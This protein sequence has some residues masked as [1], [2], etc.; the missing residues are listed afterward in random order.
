MPVSEGASRTAARR[1]RSWAFMLPI[2]WL[3]LTEAV[4]RE[5]RVDRVTVVH[6]DKLP[7]VRR[8][9]GL[10]V[11]VSEVKRAIR[12]WDFFDSGEAFAVVRHT[13]DPE[14]IETKAMEIIREELA[15]LAASQLGYS[16]RS[17]MG[18]IVAPGEAYHPYVSYLAVSD[19]D[20]TRFG[21]FLKRTA[22]IGQVVLDGRW[23]NYQD[24]VFF[25]RLLK[26]LRGEGGVERGWREDLRRVAVMIG[27]SIGAADVLKSFLWNWVALETLLTRQ[28][29]GVGSVLPERAEALLGW[30]RLSREPDVTLW[31]AR[32]YEA[33]IEEIY[34][35]RNALLHQGKR[36]GI[37]EDDIVFTD[38]LLLNLLGNLVARPDIFSSKDALVEFSE[39]VRAERILGV[40]LR[41]RPKDLRFV[42]NLP[43]PEPRLE[44]DYRLGR[45]ADLPE[46]WRAEAAGPNGGAPPENGGCFLRVS[47][48]GGVVVPVR[49]AHVADGGTRILDARAYPRAPGRLR[50]GESAMFFAPGRELA[51]RLLERGNS[52]FG[53]A[54]FVVK[55]TLTKRHTKSVEITDLEGWT[56]GA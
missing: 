47:N 18:P 9:L 50:P 26:I 52:G 3:V 21:N 19:E 56:A 2:G 22:P 43:R 48:V 34:R 7:R 14:E 20:R 4:G 8:R 30:A 55:E 24:K 17:Q 23:K 31:E 54:A 32:E 40:R 5:F 39:K 42:D 11:P 53:W 37:S 35:K 6:R 13:G 44:M 16:K 10:G 28:E 12:G 15:V 36:E 45:W 1:R 27:E 25:T 33:R 38:H 46:E 41:V 49:E 51:T 29:S